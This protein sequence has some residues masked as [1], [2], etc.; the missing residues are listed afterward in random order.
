MTNP[1]KQIIKP[2]QIKAK[3]RPKFKA[4]AELSKAAEKKPCLA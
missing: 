3:K 4:G 2:L 1:S